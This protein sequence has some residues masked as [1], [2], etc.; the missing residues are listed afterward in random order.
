[1]GDDS[2]VAW[3]KDGVPTLSEFDYSHFDNS[4]KNEQI[5]AELLLWTTLGVPIGAL[6]LLA[7][8]YRAP[9]RVRN[10]SHA[11]SFVIRHSP[12][13]TANGVQR[14]RRVTGAPTTSVGN[15]MVNLL[16]I[17][18][19]GHA[20]EPFS[21]A[22]WDL[23]GLNCKIAIHHDFDSPDVTFLRGIWLE[24]SDGVSHWV[25]MPSQVCKLCKIIKTGLSTRSLLRFVHSIAR[26]Y[27]G[28]PDNMP[29]LGAYLRCLLRCGISSDDV[30]LLEDHKVRV[31]EVPASLLRIP[32]VEWFCERYDVS[33][34]ELYEC[35]EI[36]DSITELPYFVGHIVFARVA[37]DYGSNP[38]E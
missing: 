21:Q 15:T 10:R 14:M 25:P 12:G 31:V 13:R 24:H 36:L 30:H 8:V 26:G 3:M 18:Q 27:S 2:V 17:L 35:E 28:V 16:A 7:A 29:L 37:N 11:R 6:G 38:L 19:A 1:M 32:A 4:Q 9:Q 5:E 20:A 34:A 33:P 22:A 23:T